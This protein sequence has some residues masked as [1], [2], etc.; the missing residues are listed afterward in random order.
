MNES[1]L[2]PDST[3]IFLIKHLQA[4]TTLPSPS[5]CLSVQT[6]VTQSELVKSFFI[7][8]SSIRTALTVAVFLLSVL[9]VSFLF[10]SVIVVRS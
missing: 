4:A 9:T 1:G 8:P 5:V 3:L 6:G 2:M 7:P 10:L